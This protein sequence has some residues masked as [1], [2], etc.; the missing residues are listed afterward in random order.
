VTQATRWNKNRL[1]KDTLWG[2]TSLSA[3]ATNPRSCPDR[4]HPNATCASA[5]MTTTL[6]CPLGAI[7]VS[8]FCKALNGSVGQAEA[9]R[10]A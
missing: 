2:A 6:A 9:L 7:R 1:T 8:R 5:E 3:L 10:C 4:I